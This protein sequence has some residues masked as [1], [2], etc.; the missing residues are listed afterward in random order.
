MLFT[1]QRNG[2]GN[3]LV[4]NMEKELKTLT[5][6]LRV[7][8]DADS[9]SAEDK[10]TTEAEIAELQSD[11]TQLKEQMKQ[12]AIRKP[13]LLVRFRIKSS[14]NGGASYREDRPPTRA[15]DRQARTARLEY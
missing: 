11:E 1:K 7:K 6:S 9:P 15:Q 10:I 14:T 12:L 2:E 5:S 3:G 4:W 13:P 8:N